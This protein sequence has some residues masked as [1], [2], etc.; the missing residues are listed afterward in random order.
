[1][2]AVYDGTSLAEAVGLISLGAGVA[3]VLGWAYWVLVPGGRR[4][5]QQ[6]ADRLRNVD[7]RLSVVVVERDEA[8]AEVQALRAAYRNEADLLD[9]VADQTGVDPTAFRRV[10]AQ[11]YLGRELVPG[12]PVDDGDEVRRLRAEL[13]TKDRQLKAASAEIQGIR[14]AVEALA[15]QPRTLDEP[16]PTVTLDLRA[17]A[18]VI[19]LCSRGS[20]E[21]AD[22]GVKDRAGSDAGGDDLSRLARAE[23][24]VR[25][26]R[27]RLADLSVANDDLGTRLDQR[28]GADERLRALIDELWA[29]QQ[30]T[31][32]DEPVR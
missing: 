8:R 4:S 7:R 25:E 16:T 13:V 14:T 24:E 11:E 28:R 23:N 20:T 5:Q 27:A 3:A 26:L 18:P 17:S 6:L 10:V 30:A 2:L 32:G 21:V 19:D 12:P 1:M 22:L 29:V 15:A 31:V 9:G